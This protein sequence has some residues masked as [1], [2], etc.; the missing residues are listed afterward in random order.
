[1]FFKSQVWMHKIILFWSCS[2]KKKLVI[3]IYSKYFELYILNLKKDFKFI[4]CAIWFDW[5]I[6]VAGIGNLFCN[7]RKSIL[8]RPLYAR[9]MNCFKKHLQVPFNS[10]FWK[11]A[12]HEYV[13]C[14]EVRKFWKFL[15]ATFVCY[16]QSQ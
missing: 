13:G 16:F 3:L 6:M 11:A 5:M 7:V 15:F 2:I 14:R 4:F 9:C 8:L 10:N 12:P 1:M